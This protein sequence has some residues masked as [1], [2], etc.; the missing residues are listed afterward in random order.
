MKVIPIDTYRKKLS[1]DRLHFK[2]QK[3]GRARGV[4]DKRIRAFS[5]SHPLTHSLQR[6]IPHFTNTSTIPRPHSK[7]ANTAY[8]SAISATLP[9]PAAHTV[10]TA[11]DDADAD[12]DADGAA[13]ANAA[14][15]AT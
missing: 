14:T 15:T 7:L 2:I 6:K 11:H 12:A 9:H 8:P 1:S 5:C 4:Y 13:N 10:L 3:K